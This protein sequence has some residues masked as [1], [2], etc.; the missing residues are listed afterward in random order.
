[1]RQIGWG[2]AVGDNCPKGLQNGIKTSNIV[3]NKNRLTL[4]VTFCALGGT[5]YTNLQRE[6]TG[7]LCILTNVLLVLLLSFCLFL[8]SKETTAKCFRL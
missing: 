1:M 3:S 6:K 7:L 4:P 2:A 5:P 8:T